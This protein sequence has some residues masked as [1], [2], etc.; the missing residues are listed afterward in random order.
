RDGLDGRLFLVGQIDDGRNREYHQ[1]EHGEEGHVALVAEQPGVGE[2]ASPQQRPDTHFVE[3]RCEHNETV[4][5]TGCDPCLHTLAE[6]TRRCVTDVLKLKASRL[7]CR[8]RAKIGRHHANWPPRPARARGAQ[9]LADA[10]AEAGAEADPLQSLY[11][12]I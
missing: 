2:S 7:C 6:M 5:W 9:D 3:Q 11:D 8:A 10:V 12:F 1:A 4:P